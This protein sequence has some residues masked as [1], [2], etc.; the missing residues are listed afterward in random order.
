MEEEPEARE[1]R[2]SEPDLTHPEEGTT[3]NEDDRFDG[4]LSEH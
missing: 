4:N 3:E 1:E 2:R